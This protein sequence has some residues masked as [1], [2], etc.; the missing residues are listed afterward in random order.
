[1]RIAVLLDQWHAHGGGLERYL[2][3]VLPRLVDRG[4]GIL[5]AAR[6][7]S[8]GT[9]E[10]VTPRDLRRG[11]FLPRPWSDW[12]EAREA[13]RHSREWGADVTWGLRSIPVQG[14]LWQPMG[15]SGPD[16]QKARGHFPSRRTRALLRL[17]EQTLQCASMVLPMSPMV[18]RQ[19][20]E[21]DSAKPQRMMP[22]PLLEPAASLRWPGR[23]LRGQDAADPLRVLH[24]GRDP[25][26]HGAAAAVAWFR[27]LGP[28][29][30]HARLDL[31]AKTIVHAERA[32]GA[33]AA[34]L[35]QEQVFLHPW[36]GGFRAA[37]ADAD[38]LFHPT[39]YDSFSLVCLEAAASG[40]PVVT[41]AAAGVAELL[42]RALCAV[43]PRALPEVAAARGMELLVGASSHSRGAWED[44]V[45]GVR[46]SFDLDQHVVQLESV[47]EEL[48]RSPS[49]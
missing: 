17:E 48:H 5:L 36:D 47:L 46:A 22:L 37:L 27:C 13:L 2:D 7:A 40:V 43:E 12:Q 32:L 15:G 38:L 25:L 44:L 19:I 4:H 1:M 24:C 30:I 8:I 20:A 33:T 45:E 16:V 35:E 10:G 26:R 39:L 34:D 21:R 18:E 42:P 11:R 29:G 23:R 9:P 6:G 14:A 31:W 28:R 49:S 41:T 3:H